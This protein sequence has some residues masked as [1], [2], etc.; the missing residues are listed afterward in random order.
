MNRISKTPRGL[1]VAVIGAGP[2]GLAAA[3][4]LLARGLPVKVYERAPSVA[5]RIEDWRHVRLFSPWAYNIDQAARALLDRAG[6]NA[7]E[8]GDFPTGGDLID[9]Y[10]AP[11]AATAEIAPVVEYGAEILSVAR[12]GRDK[13]K[14]AGRVD[15]PFVL[16]IKDGA[17]ATRRDLALAVLDCSGSW[18]NPN[19]IG[20]DGN[21]VPGEAEHADRI[22]YGIPD[23]LGTE[24][25]DYAGKSVLVV[26]AG[27]SAANALIDL[28]RL[29]EAEP[30]TRIVWS[31]RGDDLGRLVGG[32]AKDQLP[33][34]G[35]LGQAI[36]A[37][38]DAGLIA[39][40]LKSEV[41][42]L[43]RTG[44]A[45]AVD[46]ASRDGGSETIVV[47]RI[48][49]A[50]G[51]RP[52]LD[53]L[54]EIRLELDPTTESARTLAPLIDPNVHSCGTVRPHGHRELAHPEAG[55]YIAGVKSYGRAPTFLLAT[56]YE[57][58]R[59]IAAAL[60]GDT[61]SADDVKL[62]LPET[63][64]CGVP[65]KA[66]AKPRI[67]VPAVAETPAPEPA[68]TPAPVKAE[69]PCCGPSCCGD[70][71][72]PAKEDAKAEAA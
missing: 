28:A 24:R 30:A 9:R 12:A 48:V 40:H 31:V 56:G 14:S 43:R 26:G 57:Q 61:A 46:I 50:T 63:G 20:V 37:L 65:A 29:A 25:R 6:W 71:R 72:Q 54:R 47:D 44:D 53:M 51:Q 21:P 39:L 69:A 58:V 18:R 8:P 62:I 5:G 41:R 59:S 55:F 3:A 45:L 38:S 60:A 15:A 17:G 35:A 67:R 42:A 2:V 66:R 52:Q 36:A 7:P 1:P 11:L 33:A 32:G 10:L 13:M 64:A 19:P 70:E 16:T 4:H 68:T 27:H 34:R 22:R 49:V 23:V